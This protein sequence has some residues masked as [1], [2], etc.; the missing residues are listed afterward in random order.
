MPTSSRAALAAAVLALA[1]L[2]R[3]DPPPAREAA[4]GAP[5]EDVL[6]SPV[7]RALSPEGLLSRDVDLD[8]N[9]LVRRLAEGGAIVERTVEPSGRIVAERVAGSCSDL[10]LVEEVRDARG[11]TVRMVRD[12]SGALVRFAVGSNGAPSGAEIASPPEGL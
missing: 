12:P 5:D 4:P 10:P 3:A 7:E 1:P 2:A 6:D 9:I 11:G 8:G